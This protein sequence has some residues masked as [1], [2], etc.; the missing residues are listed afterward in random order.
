MVDRGARVVVRRACEQH[1]S[2]ATH[3]AVR[4]VDE[5]HNPRVSWS[6]LERQMSGRPENRRPPSLVNMLK[7][8]AHQASRKRP[9]YTPA[10]MDDR[11]EEPFVPYAELHCHSDFSFLD[12][13]SDPETLIEEAVRLI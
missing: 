4:C 12:G 7:T 1:A 8:T 5:W 13:A 10:A 6:D 9:A 11:P 2:V 3:R